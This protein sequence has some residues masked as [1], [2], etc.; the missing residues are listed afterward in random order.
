MNAENT[1]Q[2]VSVREVARR[3][4][5]GTRRVYELIWKGALRQVRLGRTVRVDQG[6]LDSFIARGGTET[7]RKP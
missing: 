4:G 2:L 1:S 5:V 7:G 3:L 6:E